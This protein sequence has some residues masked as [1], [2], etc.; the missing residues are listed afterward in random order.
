MVT[1]KDFAEY[2]DIDGLIHTRKCPDGKASTLN[3]VCYTGE[4]LALLGWTMLQGSDG[5]D[6]AMHVQ[7]IAS[8][9]DHGLLQRLPLKYG[10][11]DQEGPDD[12]MG[13]F[14]GLGAASAY[15][16][17]DDILQYGRANFWNMNNVQPDKFTLN[18]WF[19][20]FP[21]IIGMGYWAAQRRAPTLCNLW[22][23][24]TLY[25]S[26]RKSWLVDQDAYRF[27]VLLI[28]CHFNQLPN[29]QSKIVT[30]AALWWWKS[31]WQRGYSME[32]IVA[33]YLGESDNPLVRL[34]AQYESEM[35]F[36]LGGK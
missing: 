26:Q 3:G 17:I 25:T 32:Q 12:Y 23:A 6:P 19:G 30:K 33:K 21:Q 14:A 31:F 35:K 15:H 16:H 36:N 22:A 10:K 28:A 24:A 27:S 7:A 29:F 1:L 2:T 11:T 8:C 34:Y 18:S 4:V 9:S 20:R 5:C 13:A